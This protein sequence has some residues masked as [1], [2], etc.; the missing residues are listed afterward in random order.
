[1]L[2]SEGA[3]VIIHG[4]TDALLKEKTT[5]AKGRKRVAGIKRNS[6]QLLHLVNQ[7]L[8]LVS[9]DVKQMQVH[10]KHGDFIGFVRKCVSFY[11]PL[12]SAFDDDAFSCSDNFIMLISCSIDVLCFISLLFFIPS[13]IFFP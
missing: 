13:F 12:Y 8:D 2:L 9:L 4:L 3:R 11:K 5:D 6:D 7:M 1:M 10:Y